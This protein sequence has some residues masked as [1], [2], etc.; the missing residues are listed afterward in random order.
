MAPP[1]H[2]PDKLLGTLD[3]LLDQAVRV[4]PRPRATFLAAIQ[5][6]NDGRYDGKKRLFP[7]L[8]VH[9]LLARD[10]TAA[11]DAGVPERESEFLKRV[12]VRLL[13]G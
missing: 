5:A 1:A 2:R 13:A 3:R 6:M 7:Q 9:E 11:V 4:V 8:Q 12:S 10:I